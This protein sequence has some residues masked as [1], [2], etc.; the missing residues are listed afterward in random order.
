MKNIMKKLTGRLLAF[1]ALAG[2]FVMAGCGDDDEFV[3]TQTIWEVVQE[4]DNLN[5]LEAE[6]QAAGLDDQ[7][8]AAGSMTLFAP[9]DAAMSTLLTTLGLPDFGSV[10]NEVVQAV[11]TYHIANQQILADEI[12]EGT[13]FTTLEGED[14]TVEA[15]PVLKTGATTDAGF[16][17]TNIIATNG[18]VHIVD[19]VLVPPSIGALI[20]QTLG[21][22]AQPIFLAKDFT[23]LKEAIMAADEFATGA[24]LNTLTNM[25]ISRDIDGEPNEEVLTVFAPTNATFNAAGIT[26][27]NFSEQPQAWYAV[28]AN[29]IVVGDNNPDDGNDIIDESEMFTGA[30]YT[31]KATPMTGASLNFFNNTDAIPPQN[32]VGIFID[33]NGDVDFADPNTFNEGFEA[34]VAVLNAVSAGNGV[35][36]VIAGI[37]SPQ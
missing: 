9:S 16:D 22:V 27:E 30:S 20:V 6:L 18:V 15:G 1:M 25:L 10:S 21:T 11:L 29:H 34:E 14:I 5:L 4:H 3:P 23:L 7:L 19:V 36:H 26:A 24:G 8:S 35:I 12:T 31:T 32:G 2:L 13:T 17:E 37:L 33:S 28:I